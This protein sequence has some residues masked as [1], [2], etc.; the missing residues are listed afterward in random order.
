MVSRGDLGH[1]PAPPSPAV[2]RSFPG[3][4]SRKYL[5]APPSSPPYWHQPSQRG[6]PEPLSRTL[7][8]QSAMYYIIF[9]IVT[10]SSRQYKIFNEKT[11]LF[12][13]LRLISDGRISLIPSVFETR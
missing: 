10:L 8:L 11:V 6:P 2:S 5:A 1:H 13:L 9:N 7:W 12:P 4:L 3:C